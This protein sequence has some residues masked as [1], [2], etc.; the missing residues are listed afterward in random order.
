MRTAGQLDLL[1]LQ[2]QGRSDRR[3][4]RTELR[5]DGCRRGSCRTTATRASGS[6]R[7]RMQIAKALLDFPDF[8]RLGLM[9]GLERRP[10]EPRAR[11]MF[12]DV[13]AK[14]FDM[15]SHRHQRARARA[16]RRTGPPVGHLCDRG[17]RR[18]VHRQGDRRRLRR[19]TWRYSRSTLAAVYDSADA[20]WICRE[21]HAMTSPTTVAGR[22]HRL[23]QHRHRPDDQDH[24]HSKGPLDDGA[25]WSASTPPP[26]D[27]RA[28]RASACATTHEGVEGLMR[29]PVFDDIEF[30]FDATS[31]GAHVKNGRHLRELSPAS[32]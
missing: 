8:I 27:W 17:R 28:P 3:G 1:A 2:G 29:L 6:T 9:L 30:V 23:R 26:T 25:R 14:A 5:A 31:A 13:R 11:A 21:G 7:C 10:V 19:P 32:A 24:A 22:D 20:A 4:H 16:D 18:A 15:L 12:V